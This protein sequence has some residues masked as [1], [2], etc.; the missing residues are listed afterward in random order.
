[1]STRGFRYDVNEVL[2]ARFIDNVG[3][4]LDGQILGQEGFRQPAC[5]DRSDLKE[6]G[7]DVCLEQKQLARQK[8]N[9]FGEFST[10]DFLTKSSSIRACRC[11]LGRRTQDLRN[12]IGRHRSNHLLRTTLRAAETCC[13]RLAAWW[14]PRRS[15]TP[16]HSR[17]NSPDV[18]SD[19]NAV[20]E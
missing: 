3:P 8:L 2:K 16:P 13:T 7:H 18:D 9:L 20:A 5:K 4:T 15:G 19:F 12:R 10:L 6:S 1:M 11:R 17:C 14:S